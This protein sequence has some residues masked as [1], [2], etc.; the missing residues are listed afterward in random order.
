VKAKLTPL[1]VLAAVRELRATGK[2]GPIAVDGAPHLVPLLA[3]DLRA[4]G[5]PSAVRE[6]A[7]AGSAAL[8]WIGEADEDKLRAA[9]RAHVPIVAVTQAD[10]LPY[11][12][13]TDLVRARPGESFPLEE[14]AAA[15]AHKLG[16]DG[17]SLAAALPVLRA[18]VVDELIAATSRQNALLAGAVFIPGVNFPVLTLNQVRLVLRIGLAHGEQIDGSRAPEV[19]AVVGAGFVFR[20]A[21][22]EAVG[23]VPFAGWA[24]KAGI[25]YAGTKA[26]GEAAGKYFGERADRSVRP[27]T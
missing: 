14:I 8:V 11:V 16:N 20:A 9:N 21:A 6:G 18:A 23:L 10:R 25:A 1:A 13:D 4:G 24:V 27:G 17:P 3:R 22:R 7:A 5:T 2:A 19:A 15:L 12:L 26:L